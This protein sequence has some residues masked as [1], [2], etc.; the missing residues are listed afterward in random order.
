MAPKKPAT[1]RGDGRAAEI[2]HGVASKAGAMARQ[3]SLPDRRSA[4]KK[5]PPKENTR[6][7]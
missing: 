7:R 6:A 1:R 5:H 4:W 2:E 3:R